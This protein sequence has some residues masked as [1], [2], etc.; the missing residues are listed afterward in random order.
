LESINKKNIKFS[1]D[2]KKNLRKLHIN[3]SN[4][5]KVNVWVKKTPYDIRDEALRDLLKAFKT[6]FSKGEQF[7]MKFKSKKNNSD[8]I[9]ISKKY[10]KSSG[11]F[12]PRFFGKE[13]IRSFE[14]LPE[15]L[16]CD[17]R[18]IKNNLGEFYLCIPEKTRILKVDNQNLDKR[19]IAL[20]PG[21]RTFISG[22][23]L[24]RSIVNYGDGDS[25]RI[26]SLLKYS[27]NLKS[28]MKKGLGNKYRMRRALLRMNKKITNL[29]KDLHYK[30]A[31]YLCKNFGYKVWSYAPN[32]KH[33]PEAHVYY[34]TS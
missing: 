3:N 19:I 28:R 6:S 16:A 32:D 10:Y 7:K 33:E 25:R 20:D 24:D 17:S 26:Y 2:I 23:S 29:V 8:S 15:Q 21:I 9:V 5:D 30:L 22:F 14:K 13:P 1:D 18:L 27:D 11:I 34:F 12:F 31:N 4:F